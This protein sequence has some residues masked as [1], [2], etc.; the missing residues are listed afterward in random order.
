MTEQDAFD[1]RVRVMLEGQD[2]IQCHDLADC[3][4]RDPFST[5]QSLL[6]LMKRGE[7]IEMRKKNGIFYVKASGPDGGRSA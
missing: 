6:R 3:L 4:D 1:I 5:R 2:P 7:V